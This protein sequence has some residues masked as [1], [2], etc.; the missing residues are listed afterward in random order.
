[1]ADWRDE[2]KEMIADC[3]YREKKTSNWEKDFLASLQEH[4]DDQTKVLSAKQIDKLNDI[5]E[6]VTAR[7]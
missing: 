2:Y 1:M 5:W 4:L 7:G 6:R 3:E